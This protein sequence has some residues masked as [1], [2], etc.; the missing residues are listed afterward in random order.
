[1][2]YKM[3][4]CLLV[5]LFALHTTYFLG[6]FEVGKKVA[7]ERDNQRFCYEHQIQDWIGVVTSF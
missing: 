1:M 5:T 2:G 7:T 4:G 3:P 6:I